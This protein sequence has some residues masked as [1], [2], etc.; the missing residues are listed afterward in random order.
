MQVDAGEL[1]AQGLPEQEVINRWLREGYER[2]GVDAVNV[3]AQD[4]AFW[5]GLASQGQKAPSGSVEFVSANLKA[6]NPAWPAPRPY[7]VRLVPLQQGTFRVGIVGLS[8]APRAEGRFYQVEDAEKD[9]KAILAELEPQA[10][11]IVLVTNLRDGEISRL[12][13]LSPKI[14]LVVSNHPT[15][16]ELFSDSAGP[17]TVVHAF[18]RGRAV[19]VVEAAVREGRLEVDSSNL[20]MLDAAVPDDPELLDFVARAKAD[21]S[22]AQQRIAQEQRPEE[23]SNSPYVTSFSCAS[24]HPQAFAVWRESKHARAFLAL[25]TTGRL[26]DSRCVA[27]HSLGFGE[28]GGFKNAA[29]TPELKDVQCESCHGPGRDHAQTPGSGYGRNAAARCQTCHTEIDNPDF[30]FEKYWAP[31]RH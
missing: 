15:A 18:E 17:A 31:I 29:A 20:V 27:C 16:G 11:V 24:C 2:L 25:S 4:L 6:R 14:L 26:W 1:F 7:V 5:D 22:A 10:D 8:Q 19:T 13:P 9:A 28:P 23:M 12:L 3:T 30:K 21:I